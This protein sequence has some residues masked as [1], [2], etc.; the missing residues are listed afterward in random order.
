[1]SQRRQKKSAKKAVAISLYHGLQNKIKETDKKI[2]E[3]KSVFGEHEAELAEIKEQ[4]GV[5]AKIE[6]PYVTG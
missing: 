1:M 6:S 5:E 3:I 2:E 4:T